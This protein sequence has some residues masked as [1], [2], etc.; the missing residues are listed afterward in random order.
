MRIRKFSG[1]LLI[2]CGAVFMLVP[3]S[4]SQQMTKFDR[5]RAQV[6]LKEIA[7]EVSKHYYDPKFH[8]I[9][10]GKTVQEAR[11][12]IDNATSINA[13][14]TDIAATLDKLNDSHTFFLPPIRPYHHDYGFQY[15][16]VGDHCFV[17]RVRPG[18][19]A[20]AKG[21]KP[22]DEILAIDGYNPSRDTLWRLGY[23]FNILRPQPNLQLDLQDPEGK[24]RQLVVDAKIVQGK[25]TRNFTGESGAT[26]IWDVIRDEETHERLM[27]PRWAEFGD[28]LLILQVPEFSFSPVEV[29][30]LTNKARKHQGLILDLRGNPGGAAEALKHFVGDIFENDVKIADLIG[31]DETKPQ[32]AKGAKG[33]AFT[34]KIVVMVDSRSASAAEI[35]ARIMQLE[36]RGIV[37]GDRSSGA[38]MLSRYYSDR[39][40]ADTTVFYA[41]SV[42]N[43]NVIM[44]DGQSLE[45]VGVTPDQ[46]LMPSA[47][48]IAAGRDPVLAYAAGLFDV[49]LSPAEAGKLFPYEWPPQ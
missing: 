5:D 45:H 3:C 17:F 41:A 18:S 31:R 7:G 33:S 39:A 9:D 4:W 14:L 40:G 36:K 12:K 19:D 15:W 30:D 21:L 24:Q 2:S 10:W 32:L 1:N 20:A 6:M 25:I 8:G 16:M 44:T 46:L 34:G 48:D 27:R 11:E 42:T 29:R 38:V 47:I 13:A 49:K 22:G 23:L 35:F 37:L 26:D 43:A 28:S